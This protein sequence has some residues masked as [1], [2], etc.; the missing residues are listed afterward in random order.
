MNEVA[1]RAGAAVAAAALLLS[2]AAPHG[3]GGE[4]GAG[5]SVE[6]GGYLV[7]V[8]GCSDCHTPFRMT[9]TGPQPDPSRAF[10]GHPAEMELPPPPPPQGPWLLAGVATNTAFAGPWGISY[11]TNITPDEE[12]GLGVYTEASFIAAMRAGRHLGAG[13]P[14]LPPMPWAAYAH[15]TDEDLKSVF[16]YLKTLPPIRNAVPEASLALPPGT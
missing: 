16:A 9:P 1:A 7:A 4:S 2:C 14:I 8:L 6:R 5:A 10:S 3:G 15:M 12:T 11:A 13:R